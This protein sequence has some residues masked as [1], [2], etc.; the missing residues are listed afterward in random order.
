[1][2]P[3]ITIKQFLNDLRRQ[4]LRSAMTIFGIF[5]GSCSIVLLFAF[6]TGITEAQLKA[7][8]G[9]GDNIA[10]FWPG[11]TAKEFQG[12]PKGRRVSPTEDD[13]VLLKK[14]ARTINRISPEYAR[15]SVNMQ[16]KKQSTL[17]QITG[18]WPEFGEM[19]NV[20]P[21]AGSRFINDLDMKNKR[22]VIFIG[23]LLADDLFGDEDP[24][25]K[26]I[27]LNGMPFTV[28]GV[29]KEKKQDSSYSSRDS[30]KGFIPSTTFKTMYSNRRISNFVVQNKPTSTMEFTKKEIYEIL[31]AKYRFD[32]TDDEA[33]QVWDTT[34]GFAFLK[35]FFMAFNMFLVGIGVA[36]LITGAIGVTNIMNVVLEERTKEIGIK[37]ALGARKSNIMFQFVFETVLITAVGGILGYLFA[38]LIVYLVPYLGLTDFIG[39]PRVNANTGIMITI[40]LGIIGLAAGFFPARRAANLEPVKALK[41]F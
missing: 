24:I 21:D 6:G 10:I 38:Y 23:N 33:L 36:T 17:R 31:G 1:M 30:R 29:M 14:K 2:L 39:T 5:W 27:L 34:Q 12:L 9:M 20:I 22:R 26:E 32:P 37:M 7:T 18:I 25:G 13:I 35:T 3:L 28:I 19:R 8:K 41:L 11:I 40:I 4:K 15:W 16:Y